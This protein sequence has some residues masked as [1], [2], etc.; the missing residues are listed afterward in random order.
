MKS[1]VPAQALWLGS[2]AAGL[3]AALLYLLSFL[4]VDIALHGSVDLK[5][6][7]IPGLVF[8]CFG[9]IVAGIVGFP[10]LAILKAANRLTYASASATGAIVGAATLLPLWAMISFMPLYFVAGAVLGALCGF[11]AL[12]VANVIAMRPNK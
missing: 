3:A 11:I 5:G 10:L 2:L 1:S 8:G 7:L 4:A 9:P 6:L 12:R